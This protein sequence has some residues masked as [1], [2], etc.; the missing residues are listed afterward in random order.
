MEDMETAPTSVKQ[1]VRD[2]LDELP[3]DCS[4]DDILYRLH[5]IDTIARRLQRADKER[6]VPQDEVERRLAKW[7]QP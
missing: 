6:G 2:A 3:D 1:R 4:I 7:L 5:V